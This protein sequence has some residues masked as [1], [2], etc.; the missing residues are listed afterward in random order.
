MRY[1]AAVASDTGKVRSENQDSY[2]MEWGKRPS[3]KGDVVG[4]FVVADGVGGRLHGDVASKAFCHH[5]LGRA[6]AVEHWVDYRWEVDREQRKRMLALLDEAFSGAAGDVYRRAQDNHR[7]SG[8]A[9]TGVAMVGIE[10]GAFLGHVGDSRAYLLRGPKVFRLTEDHT[11]ANQLVREGVLKAE[12]AVGHPYAGSLARAIGTAA[13]VD[14]DTL[15]IKVE[16]GDRFIICSDGLTRYVGGGRLRDFSARYPA[17]QQLADALVFAANDAGGEDNITVMVV[18]A[19]AD[20]APTRQRGGVKRVGLATQLGFMHDMFLFTALNQQEIMRVMRV[21]HTVAYKAG[22]SIIDDGQIGD[23]MYIV[24]DGEAVV[25]KGA[26]E[27][28]TIGPGGHFG[29]LA[30]I[31][32]HARSADVVART[33]MQCMVMNREDLFALIR[34]DPNLGTKLLLAFLKNMSARVRGLSENVKSLSNRLY[35][36]VST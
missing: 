8:M 2:A 13:H 25:Y 30:L 32:G 19:V 5:M 21:G 4:V 17:A 18:D 28:T 3:A 9:T 14:V 27:L 7:L 24:L 20:R 6:L 10:R 33:D 16:E 1:E 36:P 15:F 34:E 22:D 26:E 29:E 11:V 23:E 12:D 35:G 31:E